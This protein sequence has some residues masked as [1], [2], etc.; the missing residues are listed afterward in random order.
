MADDKR[1]FSEEAEKALI[2]QVVGSEYE[3]GKMNNVDMT[4]DY[5]SYLDMLDS[6]RSEKNADWRSDIFIPEFAS[7]VLTQSANDVAQSFQTRDFTEVYL[8]DDSDQAILASAASKE[9]I[10]RTLNQRHV[11]HYQKNVRSKTVNHMLG[12]CYLHCWWE[13]SLEN[14]VVDRREVFRTEEG[15]DEAG[16]PITQQIPTGEFEDITAEFVVT[17]RF[18]YDAIDPRNVFTSNEYVYSMQE[19]SWVSVRFEKTLEELKAD[20]ESMG[21]INLD[22]LDT[23]F[24]S[25]ETLTSQESY[26]KVEPKVKEGRTVSKFFD[27]LQR[28]GKY[29]AIVK[30][31]DPQTNEPTEIEPGLGKDGK[32][33]DKAEFI[34]VIASFAID[35]NGTEELIR[36]Q[37]QPYVDAT[38]KPFR[39]I[40]R[41]LCYI[42]PSEDG[43]SGDGRHTRQLQIAI[44]DAFNLGMDRTLLATMPVM[45]GTERSIEDN[46]TV[47]FEPEHTIVLQDV[48]DL[49]E[50]KINDNPVGAL[51]Q[52]AMLKG[53]MQQVTSTSETSQGQLPGLASTTAT[54]IATAGNRTDIRTNYKSMTYENTG[55]IELYWMILQMTFRFAKPETGF[56]LMGDKV[57]N[58]DPS[59]DYFYKPVSS[60]VQTEQSKV[61]KIN[62]WNTVLQTIVA[63]QHPNSVNMI[64]E[65]LTKIFELMGDEQANFGRKLLNPDIPVEQ[66]GGGQQG[67]A[68]SAGAASN[69]N[70]VQQSFQETQTRDSANAGI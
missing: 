12:H 15:F 48:N 38:G 24:D 33:L 21:Y 50:V 44:N 58:F 63:I 46:T 13:Q 62:Q 25:A 64:N 67:Q 7:E 43:G 26:N 16:N 14:R 60:A 49:E 40:I 31:R 22:R 39:P 29:W 35:G 17:D 2:S 9:C 4:T 6:V 52:V 68:P 1:E 61:N 56:K 51:N 42:H 10:N 20:E 28:Y 70:G 11:Y 66:G 53:M 65:I 23:E 36:F 18:N 5:E 57:F 37:A 3:A 30:A 8:E 19:K 34:E 69:Q 54:A 59:K 27:I 47:R 45:K 55:S 32:Q 41:P